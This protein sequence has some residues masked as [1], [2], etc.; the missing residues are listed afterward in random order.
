M[1]NDC[2]TYNELASS[3]PVGSCDNPSGFADFNQD[4]IVQVADLTDMMQA[5]STMAED[6]SGIEWIQD[7]CNGSSVDLTSEAVA[8]VSACAFGGCLYPTALNYSPDA[9]QDDGSCLFPGCTD[10]E[11]LNFNVHANVE[12][13]SCR[14]TMC[15]DFNRD[16]LVQTSDLLDFLSVYGVV[17]ME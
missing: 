3:Q 13:G 5:Y 15:P 12:D 8:S 6:W 14:F 17:Y 1:H 11:A 4:G 10:A 9:I 16:G 7:A 2:V